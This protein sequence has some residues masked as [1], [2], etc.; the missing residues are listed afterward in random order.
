VDSLFALPFSSLFPLPRGIFHSLLLSRNKHD[1][2]DTLTQFS[3]RG[4]AFCFGNATEDKNADVLSITRAGRLS[5][6]G[7]ANTLQRGSL[8][9]GVACTWAPRR[10]R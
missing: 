7:N 10:S 2:L 1:R 5:H 9:T 6:R 3:T 8:H 4:H